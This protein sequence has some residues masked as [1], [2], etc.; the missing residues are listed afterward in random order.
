MFFA[1]YGSFIHSILCDFY[2]GEV[3]SRDAELRYL[4]GFKRN[5]QGRAPSHEVFTNYFNQGLSF[6]KNLQK[7]DGEVICAERPVEFDVGGFPFIG[8]V[9][10]ICKDRNED[11]CV[12]D[13][14]SRALKPRSKRKKPTLHDTELDQYLRQLYL[15]SI[16]VHEMYGEYPKNLIFNCYRT[17]NMIVEPFRKEG[18]EEAKQ[19]ALNSI[20]EIRSTSKWNPC[21]DFFKCRYLCSLNG[22]CEYFQM[23]GGGRY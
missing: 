6:I 19:W 5:V 2:T 11:L 10:M 16:P 13:H 21:P 22:C 3:S 9:D 7:F 18:L 23:M 20:G 4:C 17:G 8:F 14:K 1:E 15:Y 12:V